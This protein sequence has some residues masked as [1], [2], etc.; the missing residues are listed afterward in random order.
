RAERRLVA[1]LD[2]QRDARRIRS[3]GGQELAA[4]HVE[5][6]LAALGGCAGGEDGRGGEAREG[7]ETELHRRPP[8]GGFTP[9]VVP[10]A[11]ERSVGVA[12]SVG[13]IRG[14]HG[15]GLCTQRPATIV[16]STRASRSSQGSRSST[17]RSAAWPGTSV[18]R[19]RSSPASH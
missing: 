11:G 4:E 6:A 19:R 8:S 14:G 16:A 17:T 10:A 7:E 1:R 5:A 9:L 12:S 3:R 15:G 2:L 18:P 13:K